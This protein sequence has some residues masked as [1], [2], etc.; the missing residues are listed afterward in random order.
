VKTWFDKDDLIGG[1]EPQ[2]SYVSYLWD[3]AVHGGRCLAGTRRAP[4][5]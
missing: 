5:R 3:H 4:P 2:G 1:Q